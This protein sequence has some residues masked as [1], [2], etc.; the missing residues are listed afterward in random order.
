MWILEASPLTKSGYRLGKKSEAS[1][2]PWHAIFQTW[3]SDGD[4]TYPCVISTASAF[5]HSDEAFC[6]IFSYKSAQ[7][8][9]GGIGN[10]AIPGKIWEHLTWFKLIQQIRRKQLRE[11]Q[12]NVRY[13]SQRGLSL[14]LR[15][16]GKGTIRK[17]HVDLWGYFEIWDF[18]FD[19]F[20]IISFDI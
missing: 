5:E 13:S 8:M 17:G 12:L 9:L 6:N 3:R 18:I 19:I 2:K 11:Y 14:A 1:I 4:Q 16:N 7:N 10:S 20:H 15:A